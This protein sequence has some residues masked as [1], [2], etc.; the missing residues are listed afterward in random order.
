[1]RNTLRY[2]WVG[3]QAPQPTFC[4]WFGSTRWCNYLPTPRLTNFAPRRKPAQARRATPPIT[5]TA[6]TTVVSPVSKSAKAAVIA[7]AIICPR[8]FTCGV[9]SRAGVHT[10]SH[11]RSAQ[12]SAHALVYNSGGDTPQRKRDKHF[13]SYPAASPKGLKHFAC[14]LVHRPIPRL[15]FL[16][17][18]RNTGGT[19]KQCSFYTRACPRPVP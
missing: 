9:R 4:K 10:T 1:M 2:F 17:L 13:Y 19:S 8:S 18:R 15:R 16:V 3:V 7:A 6:V 5:A 12:A 14:H 11:A